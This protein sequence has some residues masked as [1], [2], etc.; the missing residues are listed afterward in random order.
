MTAAPMS[1]TTSQQIWPKGS[2]KSGVPD[3]RLER[4]NGDDYVAPHL[5]RV[6]VALVQVYAAD[7]RATVREVARVAGLG[8]AT[9]YKHLSSLADVGLVD[10]SLGRSGTL[11]PLVRMIPLDTAP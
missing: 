9:T 7:G 6:F 10:W 1:W 3:R 8:L 4:S 2:W 5:T 11:R